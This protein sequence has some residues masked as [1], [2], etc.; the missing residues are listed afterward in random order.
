MEDEPPTGA[1]WLYMVRC[2]EMRRWKL[3]R[4]RGDATLLRARYCTPYGPDLELRTFPCK[5][6]GTSVAL[7]QTAFMVLREHRMFRR[8]EHFD[9]ST[10][11]LAARYEDVLRRLA[12]ADT[13]PPLDTADKSELSL[14]CLATNIDWKPS[15]VDGA[16]ETPPVMHLENMLYPS[17]LCKT[18]WKVIIKAPLIMEV[19]LALGFRSPF[20][21]EHSFREELSAVYQTRL[22]TTH[23]Y[24]NYRDMAPLFRVGVKVHDTWDNR[25]VAA[26]LR[27]VLGEC[28]LRLAHR[29]ER[30][31]TTDGKMAEAGP[32]E[33]RL[34]PEAV[35]E[36]AELLWL[37]TRSRGGSPVPTSNGHAAAFL[38]A[39]VVTKYAHLLDEA[40]GP[41]GV[42][43]DLPS[44]NQPHLAETCGNG[45]LSGVR[46][47]ISPSYNRSPPDIGRGASLPVPA[48]IRKQCGKL[49]K[50][51][52]V[53]KYRNELRTHT[54][55]RIYNHF[56]R[57]MPHQVRGGTGVNARCD[58]RN[59]TSID[60][61]RAVARQLRPVAGCRIP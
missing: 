28:G 15:S 58:W 26:S 41:L 50:C 13:P 42:S 22:R 39:L 21:I 61:P 16:F 32:G 14:W 36:A 53:I 17:T 33:Y 4:W 48:G 57:R 6:E 1:E 9:G 25:T 37:K 38:D 30:S 19:I 3:G 45:R 55:V 8:A 52:R 10:P 34:D 18:R 49:N 2:P 11:E 24:A 46:E 35:R 54:I 31:R 7:E 44:M 60:P 43:A 29:R 40:R 59:A 5:V 12:N 47:L 27:M 23:L 20:D 56:N 51:F